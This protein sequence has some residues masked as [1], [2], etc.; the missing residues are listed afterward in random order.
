MFLASLFP[1]LLKATEE[2]GTPIW[3]SSVHWRLC[4]RKKAGG[5]GKRRTEQEEAD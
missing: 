2:Q 5:G 4:Y 3:I 1:L